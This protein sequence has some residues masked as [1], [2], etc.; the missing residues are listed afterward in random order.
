[1]RVDVIF[2]PLTS[3]SRGTDP[4]RHCNA[5][6][7]QAIVK[8]LRT[9]WPTR[10]LSCGLVTAET[11][12]RTRPRPGKICCKNKLTLEYGFPQRHRPFLGMQ[13]KQYSILVFHSPKPIVHNVTNFQI[14]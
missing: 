3:N 1:M 9:V 5:K 14:K 8:K 6:E 13:F 7:E 2:H 12:V 4:E 10:M 11:G